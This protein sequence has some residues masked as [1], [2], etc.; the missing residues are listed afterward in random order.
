MKSV[1]MTKK[2]GASQINRE[3]FED[4]FEKPICMDNV[5]D[6]QMET[7]ANYVEN[8]VR[9]VY[10]KDVADKMFDIWICDEPTDE[11]MELIATTYQD[12]WKFYWEI[13]SSTAINAGGVEQ[14][15]EE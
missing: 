12:A 2:F 15:E 11:E 7:I 14:V 6:E 10:G 1:D 8:A 9:T 13:L 4:C 3:M 5:S